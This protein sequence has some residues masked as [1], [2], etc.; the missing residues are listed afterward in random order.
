MP[1]LWP[2][3]IG[4]VHVDVAGLLD[5]VELPCL[6]FVKAGCSL[7]SSNEKC[8]RFR[9]LL[10]GVFARPCV[11]NS[12]C[13]RDAVRREE[14]VALCGTQPL[15]EVQANAQLPATSFSTSVCG[16]RRLSR[17]SAATEPA[18]A[19]TC[20]TLPLIAV[21]SPVRKATISLRPAT[22]ARSRGVL[23]LRSFAITSAPFPTSNVT[24]SSWPRRT[25]KWR[26]VWPE[27][28]LAFT[29]APCAGRNNSAA[30]ICPSRAA[31]CSAVK[32]DKASA[33]T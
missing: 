18:L 3:G 26:G 6:Q 16:S 29:S 5:L 12:Q 8:R 9:H 27:A 20:S 13:R 10:F 30:R 31:Q 11:D 17:C 2:Q 32:S 15:V 24:T 23:P 28:V 22:R 25:A 7:D 4:G 19:S 14:Q 21:S 33:F 1:P